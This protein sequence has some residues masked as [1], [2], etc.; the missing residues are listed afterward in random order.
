M[1]SL[2]DQEAAIRKNVES[3]FAQ[4]REQLISMTQ[5]LKK[6]NQDLEL[7]RS[8]LSTALT[9]TRSDLAKLSKKVDDQEKTIEKQTRAVREVQEA[10]K[11]IRD[12]EELQRM[13]RGMDIVSLSGSPGKKLGAS[14]LIKSQ[15]RGGSTASK[16]K[17]QPTLGIHNLLLTNS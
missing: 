5:N 15:I 14:P 7:Q 8:Q 10:A 4:E 12:I 2:A 11:D 17:A 16:P 1:A 13:I 9:E 6:Q 3:H